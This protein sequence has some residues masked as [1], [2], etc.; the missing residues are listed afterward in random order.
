MTQP[1]ITTPT[2]E[3]VDTFKAAIDATNALLTECAEWKRRALAAHEIAVAVEDLQDGE[4]SRDGDG[5]TVLAARYD[6]LVHKFNTWRRLIERG[7]P[8]GWTV[9]PEPGQE[10][11]E[12]EQPD[13]EDITF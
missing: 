7:V 11:A 12:P 13:P 1:E 9:A 6:A 8:D 5:V 4:L 10:D 3:T 2:P